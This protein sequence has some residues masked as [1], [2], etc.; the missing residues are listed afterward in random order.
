DP[1]DHL[2][3]DRWSKYGHDRLYINDGIAKADKYSLYVDLQTHEIVSDN[4]AKHS[5]G[6]VEIEGDTATVTIEVSG[7]KYEHEI[8]LSL[9]GEAFAPVEDDDRDEGEDENGHE[10]VADGG[11]DDALNAAVTDETIRDAIGRH[12]DSD[13][14]DA[15]TVS[16]VRDLLAALQQS[17]AEYWGEWCSNI[18]HGETLV[19]AVTDDLLVMDTGDIVKYTEELEHHP[20]VDDLDKRTRDVV[21]RLMHDLAREHSDREWGVTY[22]LVVGKPDGF[23][24]GE[25]FVDAIVNSLQRRGLSPG[26]AWAYY[27][28]EIRG[29]SQS[30][31]AHRQDRHQQQISKALK[32]VRREHAL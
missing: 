22:P 31:W 25:E 20:D 7:G 10:V 13:H 15:V 32:T 9:D 8:T 1:S 21:S 12:D 16:E 18:E 23:D 24:A 28:V 4:E 30:S 6:S 19:V 29:K 11:S 2:D 26:Q 3:I 17:V 27:G 14:P 5:G